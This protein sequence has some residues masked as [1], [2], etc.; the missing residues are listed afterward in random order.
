M[1]LYKF[2]G[3]LENVQDMIIVTNLTNYISDF[4]CEQILYQM[5]CLNTFVYKS[6]YRV[7]FFVSLNNDRSYPGNQLP[8]MK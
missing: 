7:S 6:L 2:S 1:C 4:S 8:A 5:Y 3:S